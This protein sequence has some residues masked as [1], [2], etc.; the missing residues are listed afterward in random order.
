MNMPER[1][2]LISMNW[3]KNADFTYYLIIEVNM[4]DEPSYYYLTRRRFKFN[5]HCEKYKYYDEIFN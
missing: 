2:V 4:N 3:T 5:E 1:I